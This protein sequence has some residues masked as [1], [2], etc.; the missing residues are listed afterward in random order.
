MRIHCAQ[1]RTGARNESHPPITRRWDGN[2][3]PL[4]QPSPTSQ[5]VKMTRTRARKNSAPHLSLHRQTRIAFRKRYSIRRSIRRRLRHPVAANMTHRAEETKTAASTDKDTITVTLRASFARQ[6]DFIGSRPAHS[7]FASRRKR[8]FCS[9]EGRGSDTIESQHGRRFTRGFDAKENRGVLIEFPSLR[10]ED[11][12]RALRTTR[13]TP[14][15]SVHKHTPHI[16]VE[17]ELA[18]FHMKNGCHKRR[19]GH[20]MQ[21]ETSQDDSRA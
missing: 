1:N 8:S 21:K 19:P 16:H 10:P 3:H 14:V 17:N 12:A 6:N 18:G 5:A 15:F 7:F 13:E 4:E 11:D 2:F 9:R 20:R